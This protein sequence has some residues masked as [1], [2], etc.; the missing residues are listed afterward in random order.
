M[1]RGAEADAAA[2]A[3]GAGAGEKGE[4][5][6]DGIGSVDG[7]SSGVGVVVEDVERGAAAAGG[8]AA[9][10]AGDGKGL[11]GATVMEKAT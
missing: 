10:L 5:S 1:R 7:A 2:A 8:S 3:A 11:G 9:E 4:G 6:V